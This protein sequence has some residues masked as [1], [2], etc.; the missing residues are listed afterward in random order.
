[1]GL[2]SRVLLVLVRDSGKLLDF[3]QRE[4]STRKN[5]DKLEADP[6]VAF[7][8]PNMTCTN[9][10]DDVNNKLHAGKEGKPTLTLAFGGYMN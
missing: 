6:L 9:A 8:E 5:K 1:M 2:L 10:A 7:H 4:S 3:E